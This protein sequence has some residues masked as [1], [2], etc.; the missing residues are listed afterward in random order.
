[1]ISISVFNILLGSA[2][3]LAL[4]SWIDL[5]NKLYCNIA[6]GFLSSLLFGYSAVIANTGVIETGRFGIA[7]NLSAVQ[8]TGIVMQDL[9]L[10][11]FLIIPSAIMMIYSAYMLWDAYDEYQHSGDVL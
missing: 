10:Q 1:M 8:S 6:A 5:N 4:Y 7:E 9:S 3:V 2:F 11:I